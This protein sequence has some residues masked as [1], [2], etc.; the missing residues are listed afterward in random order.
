[1]SYPPRRPPSAASWAGG[2]KAMNLPLEELRTPVEPADSGVAVSADPAGRFV[3]GS[4][5][6]IS[7][8]FQAAGDNSQGVGS[9]RHIWEREF[10]CACFAR[11]VES[12]NHRRSGN[13]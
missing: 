11:G 8:R 7:G 12:I 9:T 2:R 6:P 1:M 4:D 5:L 3:A 10:P 13:G